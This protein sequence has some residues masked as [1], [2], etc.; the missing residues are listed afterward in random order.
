MDTCLA[1]MPGLHVQSAGRLQKQI[2][3]SWVLQM[4]ASRRL[5]QKVKTAY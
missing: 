2:A 5:I 4:H 1:G 3:L